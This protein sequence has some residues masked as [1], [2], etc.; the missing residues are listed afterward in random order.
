[1]PDETPQKSEPRWKIA[2]ATAFGLGFSPIA[3]GTV[4]ALW[5]VAIHIAIHTLAPPSAQRWLL[6]A[7]LLLIS[8]ANH[9]LTPWAQRYWGN[10]DPGQFVLDEVAGYLVV[11]LLFRDGNLG[12]VCVWGFLF[13]RAIDILKLPPARQIDRSGTG[14]WSILLD[15]LIAGAYAAGCVYAVHRIGPAIGLGS[16]LI[17]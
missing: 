15:D 3:P 2:V 8:V 13:F 4:A 17:P 14:A 5:G 7:A 9:V 12:A 10:K 11:P 16:W 6:L 1:M